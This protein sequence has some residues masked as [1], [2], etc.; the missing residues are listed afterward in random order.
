VQ[1]SDIVLEGRDLSKRFG[2]LTAVDGV[3]VAVRRGQITALLGEN[4]AG[5]TTYIKMLNGALKPN[6]GTVYYQGQEVRFGSARDAVKRKIHTIYQS[7]AL[8][9]LFTVKENMKLIFH[10]KS[11]EE[12]NAMIQQY[13]KAVDLDQRVAL[14]PAGI[15]QRLEITKALGS[16]AKVLL[17]DEPTSVLA[18]EERDRLFKDLARLAKEKELAILIATHKLQDVVDYCQ[19]VVVLRR[20]KLVLRKPVR[21]TNLNE[22]TVAMFGA[23]EELEK[24]PIETKLV[25]DAESVL[26]VRNLSVRGDSVPLAVREASFSMHKGEILGIVAIAGNGELELADA[27]Y[28]LRKPLSGEV[29]PGP[30]ILKSGHKLRIGRVAFVSDDP[31]QT[32]LAVDLSVK[33]NFGISFIDQTSKGFLV[34]WKALEDFSTKAIKKFEIKC[35]AIEEPLRELSGGNIQKVVVARELSRDVDV[36]IAVHPA[37]GLDLHTTYL[38][39]RSIKEVARKG[40]SVLLISEDVDEALYVSDRLGAMYEGRLSEIKPKGLWTRETLGLYMIGA[41]VMQEAKP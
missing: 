39:Y 9:D 2:D 24:A 11:D 26:D 27:V 21:E 41:G 31:V 15:K 25:D 12:L 19:Q 38:V 13:G 14:L 6:G 5:K 36:L 4:G 1:E 7:F 34:D 8:I 40:V 17:M 18:Y 29:V 3:S 16:D 37:R 22:L 32:G 23:S 33:D 10:N 35:Y 30:A 28:G 20:G